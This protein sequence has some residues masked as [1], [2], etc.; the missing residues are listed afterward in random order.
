MIFLPAMK[1]LKTALLFFETGFFVLI[2]F[3]HF[4]LSAVEPAFSNRP[5]SSPAPP[6]KARVVVVQDPQ[7]TETFRPRP[8]KL[9]ALFERGFLQFTGKTNPAQA[10]LSLVSTNDVIGL[11][12]FSAPGEQSGTR[13]ALV[14][15]VVESLLAAGI[16][17]QKIVVW[18][19]QLTPLRLAG[20]DDLTKRYGI[21]IAG[22]AQAGWDEKVFYEN[23]IM[24]N[25]V[26]GDLEFEKKGDG[27]G[28]KSH[29]SKLVT[30]EITKIIN[31]TP[32]L[33]HNFAGVTGSLYSLALG[34]VDNS[35]RF[36]NNA[37]R[38]AMA[39]P[40]IYALPEL[41]D[42]VVLNVV[43]GLICQYEG[44]QRS[45]LHYSTAL[46]ELRFSK[47]PVALDVLSVNEINAQRDRT[48]IS[49]G[50]ANQELYRNASLLELGVSD[51]NRISV[52]K[53]P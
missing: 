47:D 27:I 51:T 3:A 18:D 52:E 23:S 21:R 9:L 32:M 53:I 7:A 29:V 22:A 2:L 5:I 11:K 39:V 42:R 20:F 45:L 50:N 19:K 14:A 36:E 41:F 13:P 8:E 15:A 17:P 6:Q 49:S 1:W 38:M 24:G 10:W 28:R 30:K 12:V 43:D 25:P 16:S 33:N 34:S 46:N 26:W 4:H 37:E 31:L 40:E 48:K 44:E 35:I